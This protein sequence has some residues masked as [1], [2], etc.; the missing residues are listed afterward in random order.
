MQPTSRTGNG[1]PDDNPPNGGGPTATGATDRAAAPGPDQ[2]PT[3]L[4]HRIWNL[5]IVRARTTPGLRICDDVDR[6]IVRDEQALIHGLTELLRSGPLSDTE[7]LARDLV[8]CESDGMRDVW[9]S[10]VDTAMAAARLADAWRRTGGR[11]HPAVDEFGTQILPEAWSDRAQREGEDPADPLC[12]GVHIVPGRNM[13]AQH[14]AAWHTME[15]ALRQQLVTLMGV[16]D[17]TSRAI[18]AA[19]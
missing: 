19:I 3:N 4:F 15:A 16:R 7:P 10:W 18:E 14:M 2:D 5:A 6:R 9:H 17:R 1:H 12:R 8:T 11:P 13:A